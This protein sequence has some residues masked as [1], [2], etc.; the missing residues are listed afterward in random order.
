MGA[1]SLGD[2]AGLVGRAA[3]DQDRFLHDA[4]D[5]R[6]HERG[7]ADAAKVRSALRVGMITEIMARTIASGPCRAI[8]TSQAVNM[9]LLCS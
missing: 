1:G 6:R 9:F 8:G 2:G 5:H 3:V 7:Q 4:V